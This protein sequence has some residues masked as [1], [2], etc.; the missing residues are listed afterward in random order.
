M[1]S[2]S[3]SPASAPTHSAAVEARTRDLHGLSHFG[4]VP[5]RR[6]PE[7]AIVRGSAV[8]VANGDIAWRFAQATASDHASVGAVVL[9]GSDVASTGEIANGVLLASFGDVDLDA[10]HH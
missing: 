1:P 2:T 8:P 5:F 9:V 6:T 10:L 7:G 4:V 3:T